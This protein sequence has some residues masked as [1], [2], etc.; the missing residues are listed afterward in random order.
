MPKETK[1]RKGTAA[2]S[3]GHLV[4]DAYGRFLDDFK[5]GDIYRHWPGRTITETDNV[6]FTNLTMNTNPLHFDANYC[7]HTE[8]GRLLVNS[9][10]TLALVVG[11]TVRDTSQNAV[12]NLGWEHIRMPA[13]VFIGDTLYAES[14][15]LEVRESKSRPNQGIVTCR[16]IGRNQNG[17]VVLETQR[18]FLIARRSHSA[19]G[20]MRK[21]SA[22]A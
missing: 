19:A 10:F 11:M 15:V 3:A 6:W 8:F 16:Q 18:A 21:P 2:K 1:D 17:T 14:E 5:V 20:K 4:P 12:A 13:P 7:A 9:T 22:K